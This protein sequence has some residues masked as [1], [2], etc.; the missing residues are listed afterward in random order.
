MVHR[1]CAG[2]QLSAS[3]AV[4]RRITVALLAVAVG[5][6]LPVGPVFARFT[7]STVDPF[8]STCSSLVVLDFITDAE[9]RTMA[10][11]E[12]LG[13][14]YRLWGVGVSAT[15]GANP[16][17]AEV[18]ESSATSGPF[19]TA[20]VSG[21]RE[22]TLSFVF[23]NLLSVQAIEVVG[24]V[25]DGASVSVFDQNS[26]QPAHL[27]LTAQSA[28]ELR[29]MDLSGLGAAIRVDVNLPAGAGVASLVLC[30]ES[31]PKQVPKNNFPR[32]EIAAETSKTTLA[33][34]ETATV[35]VTVKNPGG[36]VGFDLTVEQDLPPGLVFADDGKRER[37]WDIG[38]IGARG[39]FTIVPFD[40][41]ATGV[42]AVTLPS[43]ATAQI[44][45]GRGV[46]GAASDSVSI[47]TTRGAVLG[48]DSGK[49]AAA[50][51]KPA[52]IIAQQPKPTPS[53]VSAAPKKPAPAATPTPS[54]KTT[55]EKPIGGPAEEPTATPGVSPTP[56]DA[57]AVGQE[58]SPV[59]AESDAN[60]LLEE[61]GADGFATGTAT[62]TAG[63]V[64]STSWI[65]LL[66]L[67]N[68]VLI[69]MLAMKERQ[70]GM[71]GGKGSAETA[72][73]PGQSRWVIAMLAAAVPLI[74]WYPAGE[75]AWWLVVTAAGT[76]FMWYTAGRPR[77]GGTSGSTPTGSGGGMPNLPQQ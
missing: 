36:S 62:T 61:P 75:L 54:E 20:R 22:G 13:R 65:W 15:A 24:L 69:A 49:E 33:V 63:L 66:A 55:M 38:A 59:P 70:A 64:S 37:T 35:S 47:Q 76:G 14:Q 1:R 57:T 40:V 60:T 50:P 27:P 10:K 12:P 56:E 30:P 17:S 34:G 44:S 72:S 21:G 6:T 45:N 52:K 19:N 39:S 7:A 11:G 68:A 73:A 25:K 23:N 8:A 46:D 3:H 67:I 71:A 51:A 58:P 16:A 26:G 29:A 77:S 41:R 31:T 53:P 28:G 74:I 5:V 42:V 32:I 9:G 4:R 18:W 43:Y 48:A 2:R